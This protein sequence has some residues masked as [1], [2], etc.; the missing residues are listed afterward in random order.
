LS[1]EIFSLLDQPGKIEELCRGARR[2]ARPHAARD[3]VNQIEEVALP[4]ALRE[5]PGAVSS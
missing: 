1:Q 4:L 2:L 5:Q 3:I